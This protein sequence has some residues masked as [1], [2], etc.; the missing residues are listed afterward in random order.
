MIGGGRGGLNQE[1]VFAADILL[2]LDE[3]LAVRERTDR[4][5]PQFDADGLA[6]VFGQGLI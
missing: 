3:R 1:D 4:A 6:D 2:D 5:F